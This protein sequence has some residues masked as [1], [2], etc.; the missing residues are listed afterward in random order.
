MRPRLLIVASTF[1]ARSGDGTPGFVRDLAIEEAID[2]DVM[3]VVPRVPGGAEREEDNGLTVVRYPYW[4][5]GSESLAHGAIIENLRA[6]PANWLQ[7][8]PFLFAQYR[9]VRRAVRDFR[10]D[11]MH[12]H[13]I[14]PQGV[15]ARFAARGVPKLVTTLGGDLYAL[16][17]APIRALKSGVVTRA[18]AVTVMN[19][20]MRARVIALGAPE[21]AVSVLPMGADLV[22]VSAAA[23][24]AGPRKVGTDVR[25]LFVGR[26]VEKKGLA[27]L[28]D[29]L[30]ELETSEWNL[31]VVGDGP[32][33]SQLEDAAAALP[34]TFVGQLG[35]DELIAQYLL[36]DICVF[37]SVPAASGD[38]DGL[39]VALLEAMG[40]GAAIVASNVP[41]INEVIRDGSNGLLTP[42]GDSAALRSAIERLASQRDLRATLAAGARATAQTYSSTVIG[43]RYRA[44]LQGLRNP[45]RATR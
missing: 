20:D 27:V 8:L 9:A 44:I 5:A 25:I 23:A 30:G 34:V 6:R 15:V 24:A 12:V 11:V 4:F 28:L 2:F 22:R 21:N 1:P 42:A 41:G 37:P 33:R 36:A 10:P 16:N 43:E 17:A 38:Q 40:A 18:D 35:R 13:W 39:P 14:I 31:T 3:V 45:A 26:L 19:D 29:A 7:V 32:L